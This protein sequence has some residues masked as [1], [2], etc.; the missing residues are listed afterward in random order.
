M[1]LGLNYALVD[2]MLQQP[3]TNGISHNKDDQ[4]VTKTDTYVCLPIA[5][6]ICICIYRTIYSDFHATIIFCLFEWLRAD[7]P[8]T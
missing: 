5:I 6:N 1:K 3:C 7:D 4:G 8:G 2:Y